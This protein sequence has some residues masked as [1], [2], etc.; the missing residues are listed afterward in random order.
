MAVSADGEGE[1]S[2]AF[3]EEVERR[4]R[5][6]AC[7]EVPPGGLSFHERLSRSSTAALLSRRSLAR[8]RWTWSANG[9]ADQAASRGER[10]KAMSARRVAIS[11]F[12]GTGPT[13]PLGRIVGM[14]A[15]VATSALRVPAIGGS[16]RLSLSSLVTWHAATVAAATTARAAAV[17]TA[18]IA[19]A[20][21][22][23]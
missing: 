18:L 12:V 23:R 2:V 17:T 4:E 5:A 20:E 6:D 22:A 3:G 9:T 1:R 14:D 19:R 10:A 21:A 16:R 13:A 15:A 11:L 8:P 7:T